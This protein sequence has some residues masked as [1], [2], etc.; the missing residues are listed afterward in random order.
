MAGLTS[1]LKSVQAFKQYL[2]SWRKQLKVY[3]TVRPFLFRRLKLHNR[4]VM[5][6]DSE[7]DT[8]GSF[9]VFYPVPKELTS[10]AYTTSAKDNIKK[11]NL[12]P[13]KSTFKYRRK[14]LKDILKS[15]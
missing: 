5:I 13:T 7:E 12:Q 1:H 14:I 8:F 10:I 3:S 11:S 4:I 6:I 2:K 9:I 15:L